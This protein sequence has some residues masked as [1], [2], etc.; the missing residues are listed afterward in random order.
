MRKIL[1]MALFFVGV[2]SFARAYCDDNL[3]AV[4][5]GYDKEKA[6]SADKNVQK[7]TTDKVTGLEEK[8]PSEDESDKELEKMRS[9]RELLQNK[10]KELE[11]IKLDLERE[12]TLLKKK[13]AE[14]EIYQIDKVLFG[15]S[16]RGA[17]DGEEGRGSPVEI[18]DIK[19]RLLV[20]ADNV[21]EG[22]ASLKGNL[23]SFKE[24]DTIASRLTVEKIEPQC[25]TLKSLTGEILKVSFTE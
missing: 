9:Y 19:L 23:Y 8:A 3:L 13:E 21:K 1:F 14:K 7:E 11:V 6:V 12:S 5:V 25:V 15:E 20:I 18:S 17:L 24:G 22:Q 4:D 16:K 2:V 10:K